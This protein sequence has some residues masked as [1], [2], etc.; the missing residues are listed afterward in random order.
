MKKD[1][2]EQ[3]LGRMIDEMGRRKLD[4]DQYVQGNILLMLVGIWQILDKNDRKG[5]ELE[6]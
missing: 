1:T 4:Y 5:T 3:I 2:V 6:S